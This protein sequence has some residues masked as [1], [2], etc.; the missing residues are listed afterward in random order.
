MPGTIRFGSNTDHNFNQALNMLAQ[1]RTLSVSGLTSAQAG[2]F[3]YAAGRL[4]ILNAAASAFELVATD[5]DL[6]Q[7]QNGAF[8][9]ARANHTGTQVASTISDFTTATQAISWGSLANPSAQVNAGGQK[10]TNIADGVANTDVASYGQVLAL[11][12]NQV[13]KAAARVATV[14][15]ITSLTSGAPNTL[16]GVTLAVN[17]RILVKD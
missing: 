7:S 6:L 13:F 1:S 12:N 17:D 11:I 15:N 14:A 10:I 5:S 8:Y 2:L 9:R 16:D 4:Y 3:A